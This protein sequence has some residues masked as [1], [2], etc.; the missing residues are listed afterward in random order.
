MDEGF[1]LDSSPLIALGGVGRL[2]LVAALA[3]E[4]VVPEQV[5]AEV[6]RVGDEASRAL[7]DSAFTIAQVQ[8]HPLVVP[9]GL[10]SGETAVLSFAKSQRQFV[11]VVDD[12]A[13]RRCAS[14]I[15]VLCRGTL[16]LVLLAKTRQLIPS[17]AD[18]LAELEQ[19]GLY[20]S[21][22]LVEYG[23]GLVGET[24]GD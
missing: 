4:V 17:A 16:G 5:A 20:L 12:L 7:T 2:D 22:D 3:R 10:G 11:A 18:L 9:W 21:R 1:V 15:G 19:S 6:S 24:P 13:A 14:S 23:L 8:P